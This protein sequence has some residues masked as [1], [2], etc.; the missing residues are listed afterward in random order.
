[1]VARFK[2]DVALPDLLV[3]L[4][5]RDRRQ[6]F[7]HP[8]G[9]RCTDLAG[10]GSLRAAVMGGPMGDDTASRSGWGVVLAGDPGRPRGLGGAFKQPF[11]PLGP[12]VME[13]KFGPILRTS[14]LDGEVTASSW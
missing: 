8:C 3:A 7:S 10:G 14:R 9:A 6:D 1:M 2:A 4:A 5:Q 13:T 12:W 11:D